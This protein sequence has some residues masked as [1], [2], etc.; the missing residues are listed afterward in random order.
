[1]CCILS[2]IIPIY[3]AEKY[4]SECLS[5]CFAQNV[6]LDSYE[7][8]CINDGSSDSS[9][10]I[11]DCF[12]KK[13][14]NMSIFYQ[15]QG[16]VSRARNLGLSKAKGRYVWFVDADD[17][18]Q[19]DVLLELYSIMESNCDRIKVQSYCF[20]EKLSEDKLKLK[21][22]KKLKTNYPYH[23]TQ[24]TRTIINRDYIDRFNILFYSDLHY[25]E[26]T[27]F[28]YETRLYSP[29]DKKYKHVGYYYRKN[30]MSST[31]FD[32]LSKRLLYIESCDFAIQIVMKYYNKRIGGRKTRKMLEYWINVM[33]QQYYYLG[34]LSA[35]FWDK[36]MIDILY[37]DFTLIHLNELCDSLNES[38]D[39]EVLK[40]YVFPIIVKNEKK[41]KRK[42]KK[43]EY[44][45][46]LKHPKRVLKKIKRKR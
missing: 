29:I 20:F 41:Q 8:I 28:N 19:E 14:P 5:S 7:V 15:P 26:D 4:L 44:I 10:S 27:L 45:G 40:K 33:L 3:N 34:D 39:F 23:I 12:L 43:K 42:M 2:I 6:P 16:G 31:Y 13:Y 18:I 25:G 24:I 30:S 37:Y 46:Y 17:L 11:L 36:K 22:E 9:S 1:M 38:K 21:K 32:S 35:F